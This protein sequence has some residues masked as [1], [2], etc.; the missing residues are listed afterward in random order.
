M[1]EFIN[2][3][4]NLNITKNKIRLRLRE[5]DPERVGEGWVKVNKRRIY[6]TDGPADI[7]HLDG[8]NKL[9]RWGCA[10]HGYVD[11]F[12]RKVLQ[13][14]VCV[15]NS[16][17]IIVAN[18]YLKRIEHQNFCPR[19]LCMDRENENIYCEDLQVFFTGKKESF[20]YSKSSINQRIEAL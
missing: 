15:S 16:D 8:N 2:V 6:E 13:L 3:K 20:I 7:Y 14:N 9:K 4:Y 12:S 1:T 11:G 17:P 18:H 19:I 10:I 5:M